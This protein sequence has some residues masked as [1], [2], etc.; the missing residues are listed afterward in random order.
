MKCYNYGKLGYFA[1]ECTKPKKVYPNL[2][3]LFSYACTHE[4]IFHSLLGI[5]RINHITGDQMGF[6]DYKRILIGRH[7]VTLGN[8]SRVDVLGVGTYQLK[9]GIH[10]FFMMCYI[11]LVSIIIYFQ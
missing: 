6:K 5:Q 10:Y 2:N 4:L 11:H 9:R 8:E 3:S 1:H 7:Y